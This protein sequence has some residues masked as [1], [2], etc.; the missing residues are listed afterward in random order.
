M[1]A[2]YDAH[3]RSIVRPYVVTGGRT[4]ATVDLAL[5]TLVETTQHGHAMRSAVHLKPEQRLTLELC[6]QR[7]HSV[8]EISAHV[9]LPFGVARV[10]VAD[11]ALQQVVTV[12]APFTATEPQAIRVMERVVSGLRKL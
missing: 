2:G 4:R 5:E 12:H 10:V 11:M 8:A 1:D 3:V 7:L 6:D 9:R